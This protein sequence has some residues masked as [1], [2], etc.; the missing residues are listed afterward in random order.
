[1]THYL[2]TETGRATRFTDKRRARRAAIGCK[3]A[4]ITPIIVRA[5][6][7]A[8]AREAVTS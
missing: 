4:G 6:S 7:P 2:V 5:D 1:M 8:E 3:R